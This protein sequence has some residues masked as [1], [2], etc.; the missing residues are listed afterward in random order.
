MRRRLFAAVSAVSL[1]L[2]VAAVVFW[3]RSYAISPNG[4]GDEFRFHRVEIHSVWGSLS[5]TS[6][7]KPSVSKTVVTTAADGTTTEVNYVQS[8]MPRVLVSSPYFLLALLT[9][10]VPLFWLVRTIAIT[11][12]TRRCPLVCRVCG[13]NLTGN[14]SGVCP[15]CGTPIRKEPAEKC[16]SPA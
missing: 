8:Y 15:E 16:R 11:R 13:Y 10:A 12:R 5:I 4:I 2:S 1:V 3:I 7:T 14:T 9:G 6:Q